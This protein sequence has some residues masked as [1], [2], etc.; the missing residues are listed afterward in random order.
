MSEKKQR[1]VIVEDHPMVREHIALLINKEPDME[2]CGEADNIQ[3]A[4]AI[5][6]ETSPNL[7]I[8]D[9]TLNGAS[10]LELVKGLKA[11]SIP[12]PVLVLSMHE[13]SLYAERSLRAGAKG[14]ITKHRGSHEV[15]SAI[16]R[17]LAGEIYL[18]EKM[19]SNVLH[20][21]SPTRNKTPSSRPVDRLTDREL[22]VLELI[23]Q[24]RTSRTIAEELGLGVATVDT[25]RARI[26]E[27]MNLQNTF[28]LQHFAIQWLRERE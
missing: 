10:G 3:R 17:V 26:K 4:M 9:I 8:V 12:V 2:V 6:R 5:I 24:G 19:I 15:L 23:G 1:V 20:Q 22:A 11:L 16:R 27:K 14:Y 25:Y 7:V 21:I 18:S 28:E 13:E